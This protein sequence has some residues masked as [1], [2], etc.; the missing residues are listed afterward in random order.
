MLSAIE[1]QFKKLCFLAVSI[2][3]L[4]YMFSSFS[5]HTKALQQ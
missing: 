1:T 3:Y 5:L 2:L 4:L